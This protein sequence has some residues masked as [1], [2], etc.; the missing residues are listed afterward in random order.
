MN[1]NNITKEW[2][3]Y[4]ITSPTNRIYIGKTG[5]FEKRFS[6][7]KGLHCK[8][9]KLLYKSFL[10]HGFLNHKMEVIDSFIS[11]NSYANGKEIFWIRS[12]MSNRSLYSK[13]NG[14]NLTNGGEGTLGLKLSEEARLKMSIL[15]KGKPA[16][17]KGKSM[18]KEQIEKLK[19]SHKGQIPYNKGI[20]FNGTEEERK[21]KFGLHNIGNSYNKGRKHKPEYGINISK[22]LKGKPCIKKYKPVLKYDLNYNLIKEY[23][24]LNDAIKD[25]FSIKW[26]VSGG[27]L[28]LIKNPSHFIFKYK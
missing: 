23:Q 19:K 6:D 4:K 22:R 12:Y 13:I 8:A 16:Y 7:Y 2:V 18:S 3:I 1:S 10:K 17:N 26:Q 20:K 24:S 25:N 28:N 5:N 21:I 15:K 14:L 11:D 9:Q 27:V